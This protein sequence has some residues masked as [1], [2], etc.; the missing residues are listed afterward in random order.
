MTSASAPVLIIE[1]EP[2]KLEELRRE[3]EGRGFQAMATRSAARAIAWLRDA[4]PAGR[5]LVAL[6]DWDLRLSPDLSASSGDALCVLAGEAPDCLTIVYTANADSFPV[7]SQIQR[8]HPR[9]WL[10]DKRDGDLSLLARIDRMLDRAVGDLRIEE[11]CAVVHSPTRDRYRHREAVRLVSRYPEAV[12]LQSES[13]A[14]AVRRFAEWL[15]RHGSPVRVVS[16]GGR[17]YRLALD[18][19]AG[20]QA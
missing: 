9:A 16:H 18:A 1:D 15:A 8:A 3:V 2:E 7:R 19:P 12:T 17:R 20:L 5:P 14:R 10:H 13:A 6:I 4:G 11:G